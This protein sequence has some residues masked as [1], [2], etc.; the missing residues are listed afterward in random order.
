MAEPENDKARTI[1][2]LINDL[3]RKHRHPNGHEY[4]NREVIEGIEQATGRRMIEASYLSKL[5]AGTVK[6]PGITTIEAL[7]SFF[8]VDPDYFF[9]ELAALRQRQSHGTRAKLRS[10]GA[11]PQL[12]KEQLEALL[13]SL[14]A[15]NKEEDKLK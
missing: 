7:C 3:F 2:L 5:R 10:S 4:S 6:T 12:L 8:P 9:P 15:L 11:D 1:A 13:Q 14:N